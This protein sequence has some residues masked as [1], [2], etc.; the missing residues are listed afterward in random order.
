MIDESSI[1][2]KV[3]LTGKRFL[4]R[5]FQHLKENLEKYDSPPAEVAEEPHANTV[6]KEEDDL[7]AA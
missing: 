1:G 5:L 2:L 3:Q 6:P 4:G 7:D